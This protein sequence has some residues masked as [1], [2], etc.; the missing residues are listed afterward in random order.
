MIADEGEDVVLAG[1]SGLVRTARLESTTW[2]GQVILTSRSIDVRSLAEQLASAAAQSSEAL[3]KYQGADMQALRWKPVQ[4]ERA[5]TPVDLKDAGV[6]LITG[7]LGGLGTLFT[8]A[9]LNKARHAKVILTG[10]SELTEEKR[11]ALDQLRADLCVDA[12]QLTYGALDLDDA[13]AVEGFISEVTRRFGALNGVI[14]SAGMIRDR[15]IVNKSAEEFAQVLAPKVLGTVNLDRATRAVALDFI[16]LFSSVAGAMGNAGQADYAAANG[17]MDQFASHRNRLVAAGQRR[18]RTLSI[19]WPLWE[20]GGMQLDAQA[21]A[22]LLSNFGI[23]PMKTA[24]GVQAFHNSLALQVDQ[25]LVLEGH[26]DRLRRLFVSEQPEVRPTGQVAAPLDASV[27][28]VGETTALVRATQ[29]WLTS[30]LAD[31]LK[32]PAHEI[33]PKAPLERYGIDSVLAMKLTQ[34]LEQS[35]GTLSK[36]LFFEYQTLASLAGYL[37]K[38]FPTVVRDKTGTTAVAA[39]SPAVEP[40]AGSKTPRTALVPLQA[41]FARTETRSHIDVAIVGLGG[42]YPQAEN[43]QQFWENLKHGRDCITEIPADRWN[44][45]R[46]FHPERNQPGKSYSKWGGFMDGVDR[47]DPLF[48]SISPREAQLIDPQERLFLETVWETIED[49]GYSKDS[50]ARNRV[51]VFVGAMWGQYELLGLAAPE[52]GMPSSSFASIAN[53]ISYFFDFHGPSLAVDT[54]CSSSLSAIHLACEELRKGTVNVAIAG[55]VNVSIHPAKYLSL[56]QGNFAASDGRCRSFGAG[57]DGYVPGEGVGAVLLKPLHQALAD[58]DQVYAV[59]K[60]STINHGGKTN[61]YT[62]PNPIAQSELIE[63]AIT[64]A[65]IDPTTIS[66]VETHGTGT[67][68]GDPIEIAGLTKA[69]EAAAAQGSRSRKQFCPIGSVKSNIGHLESAA[70][71]A[72]VTKSLLQLKHG[73]L[74]PSLHAEPSNPNIDFAQTPFYVQ[75]QLEDW[76]RPEDHPRRIAISSFGAGGSNA[77]LILEEVIEPRAADATQP[78]SLE[79]FVLSARSRAS[80]QE[81]ARKMTGFL[82]RS[83]QVSMSDLAFTLQVGRTPMQERLV[84]LAATVTELRAKLAQW[85][86][87]PEQT[88]DGVC[89]GNS[90]ESKAST[91]MLI[92]G[93]AGEAFIRALLEHGEVAKLAKLWSSGVEFD[94]TVL[95][96][97]GARPRRISL[98]TYPFAKERYWIAP[99]SDTVPL[100]SPQ[101]RKHVMHYEPQWRAVELVGSPSPIEAPLLILDA[102]DELFGEI[103]RRHPVAGKTNA[104][105]VRY[106]TEYQQLADDVFTVDPDNEADFLRLTAALH[107]MQRLPRFVI[108]HCNDLAEEE[109]HGGEQRQLARGIYSLHHL[110][111]ALLKRKI[112]Q[113]ITFVSARTRR[114]DEQDAIHDALGGFFRTLALENPRFVGKVVLLDERAI[115]EIAGIVLAELHEKEWHTDVRY[116]GGREVKQLRRYVPTAKPHTGTAIKQNGLYIVTGGLGGLGYLFSEHLVTSYRCKLALLGRSELNADQQRKLAKL[117]SHSPDVHYFQADVCNNEALDA[118]VRELQERFGEING[119]IHSAGMHRDALILNKSREQMHAVL[120]AK[121]TGTLNL[122]RATREHKLDL[123]VM[124]SSVAA[125]L[126]NPGQSD[127]AF[128]NSFMDA[129]AEHREALCQSGHRHGKTVSIAWPYWEEGGMR[130]SQSDLDLAEAHSGVSALPTPQ[131]IQ[132]L[133]DTLRA[134]GSQAIVLYGVAEKIDAAVLRKSV[135]APRPEHTAIAAAPDG[136]LLEQTEAYLKELLSREIKLSVDRIDSQESFAAYGVDSMMINRINASLAQNLGELPRTLLYEYE[137]VAELAVYLAEHA[138]PA[139]TRHFD[140]PAAVRVSEPAEIVVPVAPP[141]ARHQRVAETEAI[142]IIGVHCHFP[143]SNGLEQYWDNLRAGKDLIDPVPAS[144]WD[145]AALQ[146]DIYCQWGGFLDNVDKFDAPFFSI[147]KQDARLMDPQ[148]RLFLQSVWSAIE[149]A[150]YTRDSLKRTFPKANSANVG[151]FAGVTTNSYSLL[152]P[153]EQRAGNNVTPG[154]MPWSLAN[155]VSYFFDF[156]GPSMPIDTACSSSL[157]AMH[158]ASESLRRGECQMAIAGGVNLYLHPSKYQSLCSRRML[159]KGNQ[160]RSFGAGDDGFIPGEGVGTLVLKPLSKAIEH[161]DHIYGVI[162]AS[163][164]EHSG[165]SNGYGAPNP[166][167]QGNLIEQTLRKGNIHPESI[168][169][170]EGHGT[171]TQLGDSLEVASLTASF[172]RFTDQ[173]RFC[174]LGSVKANVGHAES[175]AGI[176]GVAKILLQLRHEQLAPTIHSTEVNPDIAFEGSPFYLQHELTAWPRVGSHPRRA[177]INSFGAGGVNSCVIIEEHA[178]AGQSPSTQPSLE[179]S[180]LIVLSARSEERLRES[181]GQLSDF[182]RRA[183]ALDLARLAATLQS[184]REAMQERLAIVVSNTGEL[185]Q[186]LAAFSA[187]QTS[188]RMLLGR[189][190]NRRKKKGNKQAEH[191]QARSIASKAD[192]RAL[193]QTWIDGAELNWEDYHSSPRPRKMPLPTYPFAKERHWVCDTDAPAKAGSRRQQEA[194]LHP[195]VDYNVST[196]QD[197]CFSSLLDPEQYYARDHRVNGEPIFPGAGFLEIACVNGVIASERKVVAIRDIVWNQPLKLTGTQLVKSFLKA[198]GNDTEYVIVSFDADH[199]RVVHSEG[200][201]VH[202]TDERREHSRET[203]RGTVAIGELKRRCSK[204]VP[205]AQCYETFERFGLQYGA[206]FQTIQELH[207]GGDFALAK[208]RLAEALAPELDQYI[209]H[210]SLIDGALQ[211]VIGLASEGSADAPYLPFALDEVEIVQPLAT[212]CYAHVELAAAEHSARTQIKR[213]NIRLL[214]ESGETLVRLSNFYVRA[215]RDTLAVRAPATNLQAS[216]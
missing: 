79:M 185:V 55:G 163:S 176:A 90:R 35:F 8:R 200:R 131:G 95:K 207:V 154:A 72:A 126:G 166:A 56:S 45:A 137:S 128:A 127:Y 190:E 119:V 93:D 151:V 96:R 118:V 26:L 162:A 204:T 31:L 179:Q 144:R 150:G 109:A 192:W 145:A 36:T 75:T 97:S 112:A 50:I 114:A 53:R 43:L 65:G 94:W 20:E 180:Q 155:R 134:E 167:S 57:G 32:I 15:L 91:S 177:M 39:R 133:E 125:A 52:A 183:P 124:F 168:G 47:F 54:M 164:V 149:D 147:S 23:V 214:S 106:G 186:E 113:A 199:E 9:I 194:R 130:L 139:L 195:L 76:Q 143:H 132:F 208:L 189:V 197:V 216:R 77:H 66:Y 44:S 103:R 81:Y 178:P 70:G 19:N 40:R 205:G 210:P 27:H 74:V 62:V 41:R 181:A 58:G 138:Q 22:A 34:R 11:R 159:A 59:I 160:C 115:S 99:V 140:L 156:K 203:E 174:P 1:L 64:Q 87:T 107:S 17:F 83:P 73:Q 18:G 108:H 30:Q 7:G 88:I 33:E 85:L 136:T 105:L 172:R 84:V 116:R 49:A 60:A 67:S 111:K 10:R 25:T 42:R 92:D 12:E 122:D 170:V 38:A 110:C 37:T 173:Q 209:L 193:A 202:D 104:I 213:F 48:F 61:G 158:Q 16:A 13:G 142:A 21:R 82:D 152:G 161:G 191:G 86:L 196:L 51:G 171:G 89:T 141:T 121:L 117:R 146:G 188:A 215:L 212:V 123:F 169:Y 98:P 6:Y 14:H 63:S 129:F 5:D 102:G 157:V 4:A 71:I 165:R 184:G 148:E 69:F 46:F 187:G 100:P 28:A 206:S 201:L 153:D 135:I 2:V 68:L 175:A 29:T 3:L 24:T 120:A 211:A 80:L 78:G 198:N 182:L 101:E